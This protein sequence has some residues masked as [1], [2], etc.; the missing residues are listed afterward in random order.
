MEANEM[1]TRYDSYCGLNCGACPVGIANE[2]GDLEGIR[3]IAAESEIL[4]KSPIW[5][6]PPKILV[7][8]ECDLYFEC[9]G[10]GS[11]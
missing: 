5:S 7:H 2:L 6:P 8:L 3:K 4:S 11:R 1:E 10:T 9:N